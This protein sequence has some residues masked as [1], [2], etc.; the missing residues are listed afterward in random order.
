MDCTKFPR[1]SEILEAFNLCS[2]PKEQIELFKGLATRTEPPLEAFVELLRTSKQEVI[3]ALTIQALGQ[4]TNP[5]L[6]KQLK[7][8]TDLLEILSQRAR[9]TST[10][11][12]RWAAATTIERINFDF[13]AVSAYLTEKIRNI[14]KKIV[15]AKIERFADQT[16]VTSL[17]YQEFVHFWLYGPFDKLKEITVGYE[18]WELW[19]EWQ[20]KREKG[21]QDSPNEQE[22]ERLNKF[23]VCWEV[24]TALDAESIQHRIR[25]YHDFQ[26]R[27]SQITSINS[28]FYDNIFS[29]ED[30]RIKQLIIDERDKLITDDPSNLRSIVDEFYSLSLNVINNDD[31]NLRGKIRR[32]RK[33][34]LKL[35]QG[36]LLFGL[37]FIVIFFVLQIGDFSLRFQVLVAILVLYLISLQVLLY[38]LDKNQKKLKELSRDR[39]KFYLEINQLNEILLQ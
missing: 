25:K 33:I 10:D 31:R 7:R 30:A 19:Q 6:N 20:S 8:S 2:N 27:I 13:I 35:T 12:I 14:A 21:W 29:R 1:A 36:V 23:S 22:V 37:G 3:L 17:D 28:Q 4:I 32:L 5:Q 15:Q 26:N 9:P 16:L 34:I 18:F 39:D 11:L 38:Y 24:M